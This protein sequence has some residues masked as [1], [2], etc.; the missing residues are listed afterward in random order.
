[1][2]ALGEG[3]RQ[4]VGQRLAQDRGIVVVGVLEAVGHHVLADA[5]RDHEAADVVGDAGR[6]RRDE[7]G[8]REVEATLAFFELLTQGVQ[9]RDRRLACLVRIDEDVVAFRVRRPEADRGLRGEPFLTDDLIQHLAR[10]AVERTR[11]LA[12]LGVVEDSG[13]APGQF[14]G[15]EERRP[16]DGVGQFRQIV[17][18]ERLDA[19]EVGFFAGVLAK[20]IGMALARASASFRRFLSACARK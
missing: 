2:H 14:P 1:M 4:P 7:I 9:R 17:I 15:L 19:E 18:P 11:D 6:N 8:Q 3:F 20:S 12:D 5:G 13:K 16:V 10:I